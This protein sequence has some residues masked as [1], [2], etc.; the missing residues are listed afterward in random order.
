[1]EKQENPERIEWMDLLIGVTILLCLVFCHLANQ[2]GIPIEAL[3]VTTGAIMC[4]QDSARAA[5]STSLTR[6]IG[7]FVGGLF[8]I[9]VALID[10]AVGIPWVF[11][12]LVS[13]G[14]VATLLVCKF[15]RMIYVQARVSG[16][17]LLLVV[18]VFDGV[19]RLDYALNRFI[20]SIVGAVL[21]IA[22]TMIFGAVS[23]KIQEKRSA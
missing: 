2:A 22:V 4:V 17:T 12:L 21:A 20:G 18:M 11:Y 15:F 14:V 9:A 16:L 3:A 6:L 8:G 19:D 13:L 23:G 5:L 1:M 7:V 10:S